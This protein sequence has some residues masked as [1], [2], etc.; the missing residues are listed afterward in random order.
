MDY[1]RTT[2]H[3]ILARADAPKG[4]IAG[5]L[6]TDGEASD[7]HILSMEGGECREGIPLC[8]GHDSFTEAGV[9]GSWTTFRNE[10]NQI[11]GTAQIEMGGAGAMAEARQD[12]AHRIQAGHISGLSIR[13]E[14]TDQPISRMELKE[15]HPAFVA[16]DEPDH[17]KRMG[18]FFPKWR[19]L[20]GSIV[21]IGA[22]KAA[23]ISAVRS[24]PAKDFWL[25]Q[26][27]SMDLSGVRLAD[28]L[29]AIRV[30][31]IPAATPEPPAATP[32][33]RAVAT[34]LNPFEGITLEQFKQLN[35]IAAERQ[36]RGIREDCEQAVK[37]L[38]RSTL[39]VSN[40]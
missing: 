32:A 35:K 24:G 18:M 29:E 15:D 12:L 10:P 4:E 9:I 6:A 8:F 11:T 34:P 38:L 14:P 40:V 21:P 37:K 19:A 25:D 3:A 20:E 17:R 5:I 30:K 23:L 26:F 1:R 16:R 13:W 28:V 22:D 36:L 31:E 39:G 2:D 7:G 27:E 33:P